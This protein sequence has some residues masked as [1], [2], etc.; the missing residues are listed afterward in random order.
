LRSKN[1]IGLRAIFFG[2]FYDNN[3]CSVWLQNC[4][5]HNLTIETSDIIGI[6]DIEDTEPILLNDQSIA[7]ICDQKARMAKDFSHKIHLKDHKPIYSK[8][9]KLPEMHN[10]FIKQTLDKW[11]KLRVV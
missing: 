3:D 4:C 7:S 5:L 10:Q 8:Q 11:L 6:V 9:L 1:T 2:Y